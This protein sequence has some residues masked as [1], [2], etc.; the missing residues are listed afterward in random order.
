MEVCAYCK[1]P[2][3]PIFKYGGK[4][5][6]ICETCCN[7]SQPPRKNTEPKQQRNAPCKCGSG[8]KYKICCLRLQVKNET[9]KNEDRIKELHRQKAA[10]LDAHGVFGGGQAVNEMHKVI[11]SELESLGVQP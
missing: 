1:I 10:L 8:K 5:E 2:G 7:V 3:R 4:S 11:N 6:P 9:S